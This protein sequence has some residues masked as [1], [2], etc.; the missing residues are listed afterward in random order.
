M[1][2]VELEVFIMNVYV[3]FIILVFSDSRSE[4]SRATTRARRA[5]TAVHQP[6]PEFNPEVD[7]IVLTSE[8]LPAQRAS[9]RSARMR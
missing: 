1:E 7:S 9:R 6:A 8:D 4:M 5:I 2:C 3:L